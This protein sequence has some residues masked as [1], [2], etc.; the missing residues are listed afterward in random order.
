M[1]HCSELDRLPGMAAVRAPTL[2]LG[3]ADTFLGAVETFL[4]GAWPEGAVEVRD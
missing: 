2:V 4:N 3:G 1:G